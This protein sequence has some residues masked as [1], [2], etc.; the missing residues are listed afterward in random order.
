MDK[1]NFYNF[2]LKTKVFSNSGYRHMAVSFNCY[3]IPNILVNS[4]MM[5]TNSPSNTAFRGFGVP[6][7]KEFEIL[8]IFL[9]SNMEISNSYLENFKN[10]QNFFYKIKI[11][12]AIV[13]ITIVDY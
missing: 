1:N 9:V 11:V 4:K 2:L 6:Q 7:G 3:N 12:F 10:I 8:E 5:R 13:I